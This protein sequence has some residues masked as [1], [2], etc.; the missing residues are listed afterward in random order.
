MTEETNQHMAT[1]NNMRE[2]EARCTTV[3]GI[4]EQEKH[5]H[6]IK[7]GNLST[8]EANHI[9]TKQLLEQEKHCVNAIQVELDFER[10]NIIEVSHLRID[11]NLGVIAVN[12]YGVSRYKVVEFGVA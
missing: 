2:I 12:C 8:E 7:I 6:Q 5:S 3:E 11:F 4:L 9:A 1:E 10:S